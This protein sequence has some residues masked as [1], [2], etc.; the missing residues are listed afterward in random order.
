MTRNGSRSR[1]GTSLARVVTPPRLNW[2]PLA[3]QPMKRLASK[4]RTDCANRSH[5][6]FDERPRSRLVVR[7]SPRLCAMRPALVLTVF[8]R[9]YGRADPSDQFLSLYLFLGLKNLT[10]PQCADLF[11]PTV[12]EKVRVDSVSDR[13]ATNQ[14]HPVPDIARQLLRYG[15]AARGQSAESHSSCSKHETAPLTEGVSHPAFKLIRGK[16]ISIKG[17]VKAIAQ[18]PHGASHQEAKRR[19]NAARISQ[20][21]LGQSQPSHSGQRSA[22]YQQ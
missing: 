13:N 19:K 16:V 6:D 9:R 21:P 5:L 18:R 1:L 20:Y 8:P 14:D 22:R 4:T 17:I 11:V 10:R 3:L 2:K 12:S 15:S 7:I